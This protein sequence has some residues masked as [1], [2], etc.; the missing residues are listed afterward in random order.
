MGLT[1]DINGVNTFVAHSIVLRHLLKRKH[2]INSMWCEPQ[3]VSCKLLLPGSNNPDGCIVSQHQ[4][5]YVYQY[6]Y[7]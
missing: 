4:Y 7:Q 6:Q 2:G 3:R 1:Q 5:Q